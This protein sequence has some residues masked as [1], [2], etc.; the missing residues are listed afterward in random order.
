[1]KIVFLTALG[2]GG[3]TAA[4]AVIGFL[5]KRMALRFADVIIAFSAGIMLAASVFGLIIP[6][7]GEGSIGEALTV[8]LGIVTGAVMIPLAGFIAALV[9]R[10]A[11][12]GRCDLAAQP[13]GTV[14]KKREWE[15]SLLFVLAMAIHNFPEGIAAGVGFAGD[16]LA[17]AFVIA[18]AIALQNIPE[19]MVVIPPLIAAG[20]SPVKSLA[21]AAMTGLA[22]VVGVM[23]GYFFAGVSESLLP[24]ALSLAAGAMI[25]V[26]SEDGSD[27]ERKE[28]RINNIRPIAFS[29]GFSL[30]T[31]LN[32]LISALV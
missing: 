11:G 1:M 7:L 16:D 2:V 8:S 24:I 27:K 9:S 6:A 23:F 31:F 19:G 4:G 25:F 13:S 22:E 15:R 10:A 32:F 3:A 20:V 14:K 5:F 21:F 12:K 30:M 18:G 28:V 29:I 17:G 26:A